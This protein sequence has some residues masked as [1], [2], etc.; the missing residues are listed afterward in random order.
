M[1]D[2]GKV[3]EETIR[4][5]FKRINLTK[6]KLDDVE[7]YNAVYDGGFIQAAKETLERVSLEKYGVFRELEFSRMADLHFILLVMATLE[8]GGYFAQDREVEPNIKKFNEEFPGRSEMTELLRRTFQ[9][10]RISI[11][12]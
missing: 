4:E 9:M 12:Q 11:F 1:R 2:L 5:I 3:D 6:F 7:I 8:N 10:M